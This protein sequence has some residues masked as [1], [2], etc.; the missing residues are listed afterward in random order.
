VTPKSVRLRKAKLPA[1][2]RARVRSAL[3]PARN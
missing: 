3:K 2:D 1:S